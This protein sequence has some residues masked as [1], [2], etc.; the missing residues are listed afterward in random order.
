VGRETRVSVR[1]DL[2]GESEPSV[3]VIQIYLCDIGARYGRGARNEGGRSGTS[4]IHYSEDCVM[5]LALREAGDEIHGYPLEGFG[6]RWGVD[7]VERDSGT[8]RAD[9]V[10][11][12]LSTSF[13]IVRDPRVHAGPPKVS[14]DLAKGL[15][16][17]RVS[18]RRRVVS[19]GEDSSFERNVWGNY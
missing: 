14:F 18:C 5:I 9:F 15:V 16:S 17:A 11:L 4:M 1:Y 7:F 2:F 3:D 10:L 8:V 12:T 19:V 6:V 13:D